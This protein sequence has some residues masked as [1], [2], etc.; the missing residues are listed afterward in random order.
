[1]SLD[2]VGTLIRIEGKLTGPG[3]VEILENNVCL[4]AKLLKLGKKFIFQQDNDPKVRK[5]F[6][7]DLLFF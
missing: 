3:Y 5:M 2:G 1:M 6:T 7:F 4:S